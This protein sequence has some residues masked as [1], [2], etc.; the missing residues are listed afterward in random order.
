MKEDDQN[1]LVKDLRK[2]LEA[3]LKY[4]QENPRK[5]IHWDTDFMTERE[6]WEKDP[7][8]WKN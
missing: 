1:R 3:L 6:P 8:D 5:R 2:T 4:L 7:D